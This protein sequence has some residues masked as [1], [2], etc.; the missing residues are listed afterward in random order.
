M[1]NGLQS[2]PMD[3]NFLGPLALTCEKPWNFERKRVRLPVSYA[4]LITLRPRITT[5]WWLRVFVFLISSLASSGQTVF[6]A[7]LTLPI[8]L[9]IFPPSCKSA[10]L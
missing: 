3:Q 10:M 9:C 1:N 6:F 2:L 4:E 8:L 7:G 5:R